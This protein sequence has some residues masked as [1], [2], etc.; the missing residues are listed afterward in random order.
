MMP[1]TQEEALALKRGD[2]VTID[3]DTRQFTVT[4]IR[5][6]GNGEFRICLDI[7]G[8]ADQETYFTQR[9]LGIVSVAA[10]VEDSSKDGDPADDTPKGKAKK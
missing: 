2:K 4:G 6:V 7:D 8:E 10:T 9:H 1:I 5:W 3:G